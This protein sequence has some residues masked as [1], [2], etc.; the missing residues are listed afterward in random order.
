MPLPADSRASLTYS[1]HDLR[2]F[3]LASLGPCLWFVALV[4]MYAVSA[5]ACRPSDALWLWSTFALCTLGHAPS[6]FGLSRMNRQG[7]SDP[8]RRR[9]TVRIGLTLNV[10]SL[11]LMAGFAMP[12]L[13]LRPCE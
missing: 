4:V 5:R 9:L 8:P 6:I 13:L 10:L 11:L 2:L 3:A 1:R 7:A 12:M